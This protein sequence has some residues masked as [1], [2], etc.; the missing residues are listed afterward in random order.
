M[1]YIVEIYAEKT[2]LFKLKNG[3]SRG[4]DTSSITIGASKYAL[5]G[6]NEIVTDDGDTDCAGGSENSIG[7]VSGANIIIANTRANGATGNVAENTDLH[8]NI[9]A[10][11][12]ANNESFTIQY[13]QNSTSYWNDW[14]VTDG[15]FGDPNTTKADGNGLRYGSQT[16]TDE[17]GMIYLWGGIVQNFRG[18]MRR[19]CN[20]P[21]CDALQ[22][23]FNIG[24]DKAYR[25]DDNLRCTRPPL[26][27]PAL[28][29]EENCIDDDT[30][31]QFDFKIAQFRIY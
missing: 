10:A 14:N 30:P 7:L 25:W 1:N 27:P 20:G 3:S 6:Y 11:I 18:Y 24:M 5:D 31:P 17:R 26:Y 13:W 9:H 21:Y 15:Q 2:H 28:T 19:N 4:S 12:F 29:C 8:I 16:T 23:P 22:F